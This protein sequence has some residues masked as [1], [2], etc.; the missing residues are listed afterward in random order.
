MTDTSDHN[1]RDRAVRRIKLACAVLIVV[2]FLG[3]VGGGVCERIAIS[4]LPSADPASGQTAPIDFK[5][6]ARFVQPMIAKY[7]GLSVWIIAVAAGGA[8]A[9]SGI[10]YFVF[11]RLPHE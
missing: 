11:G 2:G 6:Q 7:C 8:V 3:V 10:L 1:K 4:S 5:G 9:L